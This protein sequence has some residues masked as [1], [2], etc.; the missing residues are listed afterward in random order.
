MKSQ[1]GPGTLLDNEWI[2]DKPNK[3]DNPEQ[4]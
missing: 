4:F 1:L 2:S 3:S